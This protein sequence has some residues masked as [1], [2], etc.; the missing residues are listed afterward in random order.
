M[1]SLA[2]TFF[3]SNYI[4]GTLNSVLRLFYYFIL[5]LIIN[6]CHSW[7]ISLC[8]YPICSLHLLNHVMEA[9]RNQHCWNVIIEACFFTLY[10]SGQI[11]DLFE[12]MDPE[13]PERYPFLTKAITWTS[14]VNKSHKRGHPD[15]H[16]KFG[17]IFKQGEWRLLF[18][19]YIQTWWG[20]SATLG[21]LSRNYI[22]TGWGTSATLGLLSRSYI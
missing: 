10:Y 8:T 5:H 17:V 11:S 13:C 16:Q 7:P 1:S 4:W 12:R 2:S 15:L 14:K 22:Q 18:R 21:L 3:F 6:Q 19:S 9:Q 20:T